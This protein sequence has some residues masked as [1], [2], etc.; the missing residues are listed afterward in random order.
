MLAIG[1]EFRIGIFLITI[2]SCLISKIGNLSSSEKINTRPESLYF[3]TVKL[4]INQ[5]RPKGTGYLIGRE[6]YD[7]P[8]GRGIR[9]PSGIK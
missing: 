9:Y 2:S 8:E 5:P 1:F 6:F 3:D 7:Q 4:L